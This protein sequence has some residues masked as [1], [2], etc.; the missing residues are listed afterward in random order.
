MRR[1]AALLACL[2]LLPLA[3]EAEGRLSALDYAEIQQLVNRL[4]HALDY[5]TR[6]GQDFADLFAEKGRYVIEEADGRSRSISGREALAKLA[7]G[8]DCKA[9]NEA[10]RSYVAH[11]SAALVIEPSKDGATGTSYAI[12][13]A[14]NGKYFKDDVAGQVGLYHDVYVRTP[15]GWRFLLRRHEVAP[16]PL[17]SPE[18]EEDRGRK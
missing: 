4:S 2:S 17:Y 14:R 11:L 13:P 9:L 10:P 15:K 3:A 1:T 16:T 8:P 6:G 12:Y 18:K 7:G 5:C